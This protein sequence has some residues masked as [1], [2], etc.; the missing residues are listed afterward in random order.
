M[1]ISALKD[2][3]IYLAFYDEK[4]SPQAKAA[5]ADVVKTQRKEGNEVAKALSF[6]EDADSFP[7][8]ASIISIYCGPR[9]AISVEGPYLRIPELDKP[10]KVAGRKKSM[11]HVV[12]KQT[13]VLGT[14][15]DSV[16]RDT[17]RKHIQANKDE[18]FR[19]AEEQDWVISLYSALTNDGSP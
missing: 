1:P 11:L 2:R 3:L 15:F 4:A 12:V 10:L 6:F 18:I 19:R 13:E 14:R 7:L 5:F 17:L 16:T 9:G 8:N